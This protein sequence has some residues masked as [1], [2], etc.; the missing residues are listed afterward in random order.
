MT[1][2]D[3][4]NYGRATGQ[5][6]KPAPSQYRETCWAFCSCGTTNGHKVVIILLINVL[7]R[8]L[9]AINCIMSFGF[10]G[11]DIPMITRES[12]AP[13]QPKASQHTLHASFTLLARENLSRNRTVS[14]KRFES[15]RVALARD[16]VWNTNL[17]HRSSVVAS[18]RK[19]LVGSWIEG[20]D[21]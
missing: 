7:L 3:L 16:F 13:I 1:S 17:L 21:S 20:S 9:R 4:R 12:H 2:G 18:N 11:L 14:V 15:E 5:S 8:L 19:S 6:D 10:S